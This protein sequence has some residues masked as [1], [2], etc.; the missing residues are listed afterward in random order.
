MEYQ[1]I[2]DPDQQRLREASGAGLTAEIARL[3]AVGRVPPQW[4]LSPALSSF[5]NPTGMT[6]AEIDAFDATERSAL[7]D[8][9][10]ALKALQALATAV[11]K[12]L[13][14]QIPTDPTT[15]AQWKTAIVAEWDALT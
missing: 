11:H 14:E 2:H 13:K 8:R 12:R 3:R 4:R 6:Q 15:A 7:R 9:D 10:L 1:L 5:Y